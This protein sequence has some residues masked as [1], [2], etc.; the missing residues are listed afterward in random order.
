[1]AAT[2]L[3][4]GT[5]ETPQ[6]DTAV[7]AWLVGETRHHHI[8]IVPMI[9]NHRVVLTPKNDEMTYDAGWCYESYETALAAVAAWDTTR[10]PEPVGWIKRIGWTV[11]PGHP[12][13]ALV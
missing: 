2:K 5:V 9:F 4:C 13:R 7:S 8:H 10:D 3:A 11:P 12:R 6:W 1:M